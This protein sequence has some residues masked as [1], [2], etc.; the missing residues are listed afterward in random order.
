MTVD[1]RHLKN[2]IP[3]LMENID[4][5]KTVSLGYFVSTGAKHELEHEH[6][7]S[8]FLEH[9]MFKGTE[10]RSAKAISEEI[11]NVGGMVNAYT[12]RESTAYYVQMISDKVSI[13]IDILSDMFLNSTFTVDN[14]NK[15]RNVIIEEI[16]MYDDIPEE[17]VHEE[18]VRFAIEGIQGKNVLGSIESLKGIDRKVLTSYFNQRY[19]PE[20]IV[21]SVAGNIDADAVFN[22]LNDTIGNLEKEK[23][24]RE[25]D[26]TMV[27]KNG[28]NI[29]KQE[30]NQVHLC[31][32]TLGVSNSDK[33][34]YSVG[35]ISSVIGGNMSSRL[36]QKIREERGLAYSIYAYSSSFEEGGLFTVY[37]GTTHEDYKEVLELIQEEF[38]D[39]RE[40]G[41]TEYELQKSKNQFLSMFIFGLESSKGKMT[42][43]ANSYMLYGRIKPIEEAIKEIE[44]ITVEDIKLAA[45]KIFD[46]KY[47][48][49]TVLGNV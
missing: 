31:F 30:T 13:G 25:Y 7:V 47:Y 5:I 3:V 18:N 42:R 15:E 2:G 17:K 21:I 32:N 45:R 24:H 22:Q 10:T 33:D 12:G 44:G 28:K 4:S 26:G 23:V 19:I 46:E 8:H 48:S 40:N 20:N 39:I 27:V 29:I 38:K 9:M 11:D 43:M 16:R 6:G 37:A 36:F 34:R 35:I 1:V 41:I 49:Y 14:I